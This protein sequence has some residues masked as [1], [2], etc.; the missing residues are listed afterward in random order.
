[1]KIT[2]GSTRAAQTWTRHTTPV[3]DGATYEVWS[4]DPTGNR[5]LIGHIAY[6][7][8]RAKHPPQSWWGSWHAT[9]ATGSPT[10][11]CRWW[12]GF[13]KTAEAT[14]FL[15]GVYMAH[16]DANLAAGGSGS[17]LDQAESDGDTVPLPAW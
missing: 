17:P 9:I 3:W 2:D 11:Q 6:R 4:H 8:P 7:S 5:V 14:A 10:R 13:D 12:S 15:V 16:V 1:M